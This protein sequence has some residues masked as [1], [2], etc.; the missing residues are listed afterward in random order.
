MNDKSG[1]SK[2]P[3]YTPKV[4]GKTKPSK[5]AFLS[6]SP[7]SLGRHPSAKNLNKAG[8]GT[9]SESFS[10]P[11]N[12]M[13]FDDKDAFKDYFEENQNEK[14]NNKD[15]KE[16]KTKF[17]IDIDATEFKV[18]SQSENFYTK[19]EDYNVPKNEVT[20]KTNSTKNL[21]FAKNLNFYGFS[22]KEQELDKLITKEI[23]SGKTFEEIQK[24]F[25][26]QNEGINSGSEEVDEGPNNIKIKSSLFNKSADKPQESVSEVCKENVGNKETALEGNKQG[27]KEGNKE[28]VK[29]GEKTEGGKEQQEAKPLI[30]NELAD[31][32][33]CK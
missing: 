33:D 10:V 2:S 21:N 30:N 13:P 29:E 20:R 5:A 4:K 22:P 12:K 19:N 25:I 7:F 3:I 8:E 1:A 27:I 32:K 6:Y 9:R 18:F 14:N 23:S 31:N 17:K 28:N 15:D 24:N 16:E 11:E 26:L